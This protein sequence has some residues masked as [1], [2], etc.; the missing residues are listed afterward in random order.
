MQINAARALSTRILLKRVPEMF[1][2]KLI[3]KNGSN[4][5]FRV[6]DVV[7]RATQLVVNLRLIVK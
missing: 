6:F 5:I 7:T 2:K 4:Q 3:A 1:K